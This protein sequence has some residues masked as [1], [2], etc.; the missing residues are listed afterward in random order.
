MH[1]I[2]KAL[3]QAFRDLTKPKVVI[4]GLVPIFLAIFIWGV[5]ASFFWDTWTD[6]LVEFFSEIANFSLGKSQFSRNLGQFV[7]LMVNLFTL[8]VLILTTASVINSLFV[9][10]IIL[11]HIERTRYPLIQKLG[12]TTFLGSL[13]NM[14]SAFFLYLVFLVALVPLLIF[15]VYLIPVYIWLLTGWLNQKINFYDAM[16]G[17]TDPIEFQA[18]KRSKRVPIYLLGIVTTTMHL[19]PFLNVIAVTV[20]SLAFA[21]FC[22]NEL[23]AERCA[24]ERPLY[25]T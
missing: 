15:A 7:L 24:S 14:I 5:L 2:L 23:E 16:I 22:F 4:I 8:V 6:L 3:T 10:P 12:K 11:I 17:Y 1:N 20:S 13:C 21:H 18:I 25:E 9:M 19:I